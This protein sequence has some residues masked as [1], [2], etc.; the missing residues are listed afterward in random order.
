M[1]KTVVIGTA[2]LLVR[3]SLIAFVLLQE[4]TWGGPQFDE[5]S[6]V[7]TAPDNS[8]YVTGTTLS[9]GAGSA[10]RSVESQRH[11]RARVATDVRHRTKRTALQRR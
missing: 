3:I 7:A 10:T 6:G 1:K 2:L 9:F 5:G 4:R 8:V 11:R